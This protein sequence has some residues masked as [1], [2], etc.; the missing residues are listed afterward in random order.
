MSSVVLFVIM[1]PRHLGAA[2]PSLSVLFINN[3]EIDDLHLDWV[4]PREGSS[5]WGLASQGLSGQ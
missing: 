4:R 5:V 3:G 2:C 1:G